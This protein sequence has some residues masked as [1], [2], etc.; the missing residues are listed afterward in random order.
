MPLAADV[1][2]DDLAD[3]AYGYVGADLKGLCQVAATKALRRQVAN[4]SDVPE[5][6][7]VNCEDF[8]FALK[9]VQPAV[10][11][12]LQIQAPKVQW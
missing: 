8:D 12:S 2:L 7:D 1:N 11:R 5:N 4:V 9:Q 3:R 6:L 10:L